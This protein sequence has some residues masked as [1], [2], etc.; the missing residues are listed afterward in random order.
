MWGAGAQAC[1]GGCPH[2]GMQG[3]PGLGS[4]SPSRWNHSAQWG[5]EPKHLRGEPLEQWKWEIGYT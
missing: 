1:E 2:G 3:E 5:A 4:R